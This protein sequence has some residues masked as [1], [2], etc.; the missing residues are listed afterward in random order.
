MAT[1]LQIPIAEYLHTAYR[2][3]REF[4]NGEVRERSVGKFEHA[5]VQTLLAQWF[6]RHQREWNLM[7]VTEWRIQVSPVRVRIPDVLLIKPGAHPDVLLEPPLLVVEVLS[8]DDSYTDLEERPRDYLS[9]GVEIV[10]LVDPSSR[11]GRMCRG[12]TWTS[13]ERLTVAASPV[14]VELSDLFAE[15]NG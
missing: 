12:D 2:P 14:F 15:I 3:D 7:A 5:R 6:G 9:M 11:S 13:A 1:S 10:W 4:V 8:P